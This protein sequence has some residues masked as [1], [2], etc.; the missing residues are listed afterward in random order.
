M[1][2]E[3]FKAAPEEELD[4][5]FDSDIDIENPD[6]TAIC[7]LIDSAIWENI[8]GSDE[9]LPLPLG[10]A[11]QGTVEPQ[12]ELAQ[13]YEWLH[14]WLQ[15][16]EPLDFKLPELAEDLELS[17]DFQLHLNFEL[18]KDLDLP[19]DFELPWKYSELP[20]DL[21]LPEDFEL[22][23]NNFELPQ[24]SELPHEDHELPQDLGLELP[25]KFVLVDRRKSNWVAAG[26]AEGSMPPTKKLRL[27]NGA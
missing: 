26:S 15:D 7:N 22:P 23:W 20:Q 11:G 18:L 21:D 8:H 6:I 13:N 17:Q 1:S 5:S 2:T 10:I 24:D 14:D 19:E 27:A 12:A 25:R 3:P 4:M 9:S 16:V